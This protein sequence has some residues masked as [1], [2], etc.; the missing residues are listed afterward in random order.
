MPTA[1]HARRRLLVAA[2]PRMSRMNGGH[3][4]AIHSPHRHPSRTAGFWRP[5]RPCG[6]RGLSKGPSERDLFLAEAMRRLPGAVLERVRRPAAARPR[7]MTRAILN[8]GHGTGPRPPALNGCLLHSNLALALPG[9]HHPGHCSG[10]TRG[11]GPARF[12]CQGGLPEVPA[13]LTGLTAQ[14]MLRG[15]S[16]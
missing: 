2:G 11:R 8:T 5:R 14:V 16:G 7:G 3:R 13:A 12:S 9:C 4:P 15:S 1:I 6:L 10:G